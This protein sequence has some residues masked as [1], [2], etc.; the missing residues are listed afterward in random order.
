[1]QYVSGVA[2]LG[3]HVNHHILPDKEPPFP[4]S[5]IPVICVHESDVLS[6]PGKVI[7][8]LLDLVIFFLKS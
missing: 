5:T 3:M 6:Y 2:E 1:M 7:L 4:P 8:A